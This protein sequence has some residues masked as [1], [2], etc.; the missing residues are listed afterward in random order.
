MMSYYAVEKKSKAIILKEIEEEEVR[1]KHNRVNKNNLEYEA[2]SRVLQMFLVEK[3][4][5][6]FVA[7]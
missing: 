4:Q 1:D 6:F 2:V 3:L 7:N 5:A